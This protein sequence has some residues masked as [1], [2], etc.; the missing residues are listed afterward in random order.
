MA[1]L[2]TAGPAE[3]AVGLVAEAVA[4]L[5]AKVAATAGSKTEATLVAPNPGGAEVIPAAVIC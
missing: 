3:E 1:M 2:L 5:A 4:G